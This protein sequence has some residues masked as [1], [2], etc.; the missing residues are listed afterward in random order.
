MKSKQALLLVIFIAALVGVWYLTTLL[1]KSITTTS[2]IIA[3][4][5]TSGVPAPAKGTYVVYDTVKDNAKIVG[6]VSMDTVTVYRLPVD[7]GTAIPIATTD[8]PN[9]G[10]GLGA[11]WVIGNKVQINN[12]V[13]RGTAYE[14]ALIGLDGSYAEP[15]SQTTIATRDG[16]YRVVYTIN[17]ENRGAT[18]DMQL[19]ANAAQADGPIVDTQLDPATL[20]IDLG[21]AVPFL[22]SD[23]G[24]T[25]Y[26]RQVFEGEAQVNGLWSY[27][28]A[29]GKTTKIAFVQDHKI[30]EYRIDPATEMLIGTSYTP[31]ADLSSP[32]SGP[33]VIYLLNLKTGESQVLQP[34]DDFVYVNPFLSADGK[35]FAYGI[36]GSDVLWLVPVGSSRGKGSHPVSGR[37]LDWVGD[38]LVVDRDDRLILYNLNTG[39]V[40][41]V[42]GQVSGSVD[43]DQQHVNYIGSVTLN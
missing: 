18:V 37:L 6:G 27:D 3:N 23:D 41:D 43:R 13:S 20:G 9:Q 28:V 15:T 17:Q 4:V 34:N 10:N 12:F 38:T 14:N 36:E 32:P 2:P 42:G 30:W 26:L 31:S 11:A 33:S 24:K 25:I 19:Y 7:G 16:A 21:Y 8:R 5:S 29:T 1:P 39:A 22:V 40:L 35:Q